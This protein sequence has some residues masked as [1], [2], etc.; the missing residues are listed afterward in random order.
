[1]N[2]QLIGSQV[3]L[4]ISKFAFINFIYQLIKIA[5]DPANPF[6]EDLGNAQVRVNPNDAKFVDVIHTNAGYSFFGY[7]GMTVPTG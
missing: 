5:L 1:M 7:L 3:H 4:L 2:I 6:F